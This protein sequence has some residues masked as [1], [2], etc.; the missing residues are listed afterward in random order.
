VGAFVTIYDEFRQEMLLV[1]ADGDDLVFRMRVVAEDL[2]LDKPFP[3]LH[4][5]LAPFAPGDTLE[6]GGR[7]DAGT[8]CLTVADTTTC[9]IGM[10]ASR[11]WSL[12]YSARGFPLW[13]HTLASL[14]WVAALAAL[15]GFYA[16]TPASTLPGLAGIGVAF[17]AVPALD[18][19]L[20]TTSLPALLAAAV[21]FAAA[22]MI[23]RRLGVSRPAT[24]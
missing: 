6:V 12:L 16:R 18:P 1:G 19:F 15:A 20:R 21:G 23:G 24:P 10:D 11:G 13:L 9:G 14:G 8:Y 2:R 17:I 3:R 4:G 22:S 7:F 5:A